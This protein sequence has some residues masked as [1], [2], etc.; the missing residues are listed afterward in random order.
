M[1][2]C[3]IPRFPQD[4]STIRGDILETLE[5]AGAK[6]LEEDDLACI[7]DEAKS[8]FFDSIIQ[9]LLN[10]GL[11]VCSYSGDNRRYYVTNYER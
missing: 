1:T 8:P 7:V 4:I 5:A 2:Y 9:G 11:V 6:G 10:R 3:G